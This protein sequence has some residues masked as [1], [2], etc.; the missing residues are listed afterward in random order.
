MLRLDPNHVL[1]EGKDA[2]QHLD[3]LY[4]SK[5]LHKMAAQLQLRL[6]STVRLKSVMAKRICEELV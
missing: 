3:T 5:A 4:G 2:L 6:D 1:Y